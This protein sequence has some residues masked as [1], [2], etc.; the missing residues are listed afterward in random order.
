MSTTMTETP[1]TNGTTKSYGFVYRDQYVYTAKVTDQKVSQSK[2]GHPQIVIQIQVNGMLKNP[3]RPD[4]G[5][6]PIPDGTPAFKTIYLTWGDSETSRDQFAR[7]LVTLGVKSSAN[8]LENLDPYN[9]KHESLVGR[10]ILARYS[11]DKQAPE[12]PNKGF[13][14]V[15][16][17]RA[18]LTTKPLEAATAQAF[19]DQGYKEFRDIFSRAKASAQNPVSEQ[20]Y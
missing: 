12:N 13:W 16:R 9:E 11:A 19:K 14:N 15:H 5:M 7:D 2:Q 10:D 17:T 4:M 20:G 18:G 8:P 1:A 3:D 6:I